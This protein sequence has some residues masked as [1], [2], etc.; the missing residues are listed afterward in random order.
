[1]KNTPEFPRGISIYMIVFHRD[2]QKPS[3]RGHVCLF[4]YHCNMARNQKSLPLGGKVSTNGR[5]MRG[6]LF[7]QMTDS[8]RPGVYR[9]SRK[10]TTLF[11]KLI[12]LISQPL[13]RLGLC[14]ATFPPRGR[15]KCTQCKSWRDTRVRQFMAKPNHARSANHS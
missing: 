2:N 15:L 10:S 11:V 4:L 7:L 5:R 12:L 8:V 9:G 13:I 1:M 3:P 6:L 14:R